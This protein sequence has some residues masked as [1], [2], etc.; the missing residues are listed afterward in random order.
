MSVSFVQDKTTFFTKKFTN[1][2]AVRGQFENG[3]IDKK[4]KFLSNNKRAIEHE[5]HELHACLKVNDADREQFW[6]FCVVL[7]RCVIIEGFA[8]SGTE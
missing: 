6:M 8:A 7:K 3:T 5:F 1:M 2:T 4:F